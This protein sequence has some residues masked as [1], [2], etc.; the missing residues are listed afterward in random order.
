M[1]RNQ[2]KTVISLVALFVLFLLISFKSEIFAP[3]KFSVARSAS[4]PVRVVSF[5]LREIKKILF[6]H[7]TFDEYLRLR[8]EID[9]LTQRLMVQE[10]VLRENSRLEKLLSF[11]RNLVYSTVAANVIGRDPSNWNATVLID[12]GKEH[13]LEVGMPVV[14]AQGVVGKVAEVSENI[15]KV[16]LLSDPSFSIAAQ[17]LRSRESGLASGTLLGMCRMRYLSSRADIRVGDTII[18]SK[19]STSFPEGLLIGEVISV[20]THEH[21]PI[22]D[23]II[24]P[25]VSLSQLEEVLI[26]KNQ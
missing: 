26:I 11:K 4:F 17:V 18:T 23:C 6:Y 14:V 24:S 2:T 16:I 1:S 10:E 21:N 5:P 8:R 12:K 3:I 25:A 22:I 20:Q 19:M 13:G 15:S 9:T 7:W